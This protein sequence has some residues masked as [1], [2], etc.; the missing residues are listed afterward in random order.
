[1]KRL[2]VVANYFYPGDKAALSSMLEE[3]IEFSEEKIH[4][5]GIVV[6]HAGYIYSGRVAG[7]VYGRILPPAIAIILGPNHTGLGANVSLFGG[8][9]FITPFGEAK[10][11]NELANFILEK[12]HFL[13][14]DNLAHQ[15]EHSLEVQVPFLQYL[16]PEVEIVPICLMELSYTEI[17]ELGGALSS[18]IEEFEE[19]TGKNILL[20]ASSD[21]S[22][23][24]PQNVAMQKD[25]LAIEAILDLSEE[26]LLQVVYEKRISMCGVFPVAVNIVASKLLG[27]E[28]AMLI[29]YKT[30]GDITGDYSAVVG[31]GGI[32]FY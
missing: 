1:M 11:N 28:R 15:R 30:S 32:I 22:H 18:A 8:E 19:K 9:A 14:V 20:V 5:K 13:K 31:Y 24:E 16:N 6:P 10:I 7:K 3:L 17:E 26:K 21:F 25:S 27:A 29:D 12:C 23:Y 4:A 2:A